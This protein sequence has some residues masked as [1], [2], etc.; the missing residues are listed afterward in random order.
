MWLSQKIAGERS[1]ATALQ[2]GV[3]TVGGSAPAALT[4]YEER[5]LSVLSPGGY[6]WRP[7]AREQVLLC[8]EDG[9]VLGRIQPPSDLKKGEIRITTG[10]AS[11]SLLP[12]GEIYLTGD[13]FLNGE[14]WEG[15]AV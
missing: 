8:R 12:T 11:I 4:D 13:I 9:C 7:A 5:N 2:R 15:T 3:I 10:A 6:F 14:K 1:Q